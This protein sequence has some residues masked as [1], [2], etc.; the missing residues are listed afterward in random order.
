VDSAPHPSHRRRN[1][2]IA[3]GVSVVVFL[4]VFSVMRQPRAPRTSVVADVD[5]TG[6]DV[7][8]TNA[9]L[10]AGRR[11]YNRV[12]QAGALA[13]LSA[14]LPS[15]TT[16]QPHDEA[17]WQSE[18]QRRQATRAYDGAPP[19]IPHPIDQRGYPSCLTCHERGAKIGTHVAPVMS[20]APLASCTQCHAAVTSTVPTT[21]GLTHTVSTES[22]FVGKE[23]AGKGT[24]AWRG[25]PPTIPHSTWMRERCASCHG[26]LSAGLHTSHAERQSCT[27]CHAPSASLDQRSIVATSQPQVDG[28]R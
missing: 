5:T 16:P 25:A 12:R 1:Y 19:V 14:G 4:M 15:V 22:L 27:Q 20:H 24:R 8:P 3:A 2:V 11:S 9:Q 18:R 7:A 6:I 21:A 13:A 23:P 26:V 17:A 10:A 28:P